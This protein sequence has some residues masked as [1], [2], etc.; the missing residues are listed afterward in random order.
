MQISV[1]KIKRHDA[2]LTVNQV[3]YPQPS[4]YM[5]IILLSEWFNPS[6]VGSIDVLY[7]TNVEINMALYLVRARPRKDLLEN[8]RNW[9]RVR[10]QGWNHLDKHFNMHLKM[11]GLIFKNTEFALWIEEDYCS[12]PLAMERENLLDLYFNDITVESIESEEEGWYMLHDKPRL[13]SKR[14]WSDTTWQEFSYSDLIFLLLL[15]KKMEKEE[16]K[17]VS[18]NSYRYGK[19]LILLYRI[20]KVEER[21]YPDK[22]PLDFINIFCFFR[23]EQLVKSLFETTWIIM[24]CQ[25]IHMKIEFIV[26]IEWTTKLFF[27]PTG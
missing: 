11:L 15:Q 6:R 7:D 23:Y 5:W 26:R 1:D 20:Y 3:S 16:R 24:T 14:W 8:L 19:R 9:A 13:S 22:P 18:K 10:Y 4:V 2:N 21:K 12:P 25:N 27:H 17:T